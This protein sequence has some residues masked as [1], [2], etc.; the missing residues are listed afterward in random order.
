MKLPENEIVKTKLTKRKSLVRGV[1]VNDAD[2]VTEKREKT[3]G[4]WIKVWRCPFYQT[5]VNMLER[6]YSEKYHQKYPTYIGC[7]VCEEWLLFSNFKRWME[8]H[9]WEGKHLDKDLLITGNK[10]YSPDTCIFVHPKIN[11]F[12]NNCTSSRGK[13]LLGATWEK[14][15][16]KFS[17]KCRNPFTIMVENLGRYKN[18]LEAHLVWKARKHELA[19]Q[20]ADSDYCTDPRLAQALRTRYDEQ[21]D[22]TYK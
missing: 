6:C 11:T 21:S 2:Y 7:S 12:V 5:W 3:D 17:V 8:T 14:S 15:R 20:L 22:W 18:E 16:N 1:G 10:V 4:R 13:H 19:C 9:D